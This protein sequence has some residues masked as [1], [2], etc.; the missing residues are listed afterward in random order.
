M[1][2]AVVLV[3][4][5]EERIVSCLKALKWCSQ[6]IVVDMSSEDNTVELAK[7]LGAEICIVEKENNFDLLRNVGVEKAIHD[8]VLMVDADEI[9]PLKLANWILT[10]LKDPKF[11]VYRLSRLNYILG[12]PMKGNGVWPD[13][14]IKLFKKG[15]L[16]IAGTIHNFIKVEKDSL[17]FDIP[18]NEEDM[19]MYHFTTNSLNVFLDK[20]KNYTEVQAENEQGNRNPFYVFLKEFLFRFFRTKGFKDKNGLN[21]SVLL[22]IYKTVIVLRTKYQKQYDYKS[23][24]SDLLKQYE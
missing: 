12:E 14:Q 4:N 8:W 18:N 6:I 23:I 3:Y 7:S 20:M 15:A 1:I 19:Y 21:Y 13:Y 2:S 9:I 10:E 24:K 17:I 11:D 5:E 22:A 16:E